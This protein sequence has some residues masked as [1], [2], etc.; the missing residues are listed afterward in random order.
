MLLGL[1]VEAYKISKTRPDQRLKYLLAVCSFWDQVKNNESKD[2]YTAIQGGKKGEGKK[3]K[4]R[5]T[6]SMTRRRLSAF[7][8][9]L[10]SRKTKAGSACVSV[11]RFKERVMG[12]APSFAFLRRGSR[13]L[14]AELGE[15][16]LG[17]SK[18]NT[19]ANS[20]DAM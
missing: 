4:K 6:E 18:K 2:I 3:K 14:K 12:E 10:Q 20:I 11:I 17:S 15:P 7:W 9:L 19:A 1:F 16:K 5:N 8:R 13:N